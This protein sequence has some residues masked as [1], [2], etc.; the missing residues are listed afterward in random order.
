MDLNSLFMVISTR[1]CKCPHAVLCNHSNLVFYLVS[2]L[3]VLIYSISGG[4]KAS[5]C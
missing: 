3:C 4:G 5:N 1:L 2:K